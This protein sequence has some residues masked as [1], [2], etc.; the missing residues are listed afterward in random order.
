MKNQ[1]VLVAV[2]IAFTALAC[3]P[4]RARP[5]DSLK[6]VTA[7]AAVTLDD[8]LD[9]QWKRFEQ[10]RAFALDKVVVQKALVTRAEWEALLAPAG[11]LALTP[12]DLRALEDRQQ[13]AVDAARTK[14]RADSRLD[15]DRVRSQ[16]K[17]K[18]FCRDL[19]KGGLLHVHP[20]GTVDRET[21]RLILGK[22][23][24]LID[25]AKL[26]LILSAPGVTGIIYPDEHQ[27]L[28]AV[29][30]RAGATAKYS[31][32]APDDQKVIEDLFFLPPG[33]HDFDRFTGTFSAI[34]ALIFGSPY[35]PEPAMFEAFL[36][37]A[38]AHH[39]LYAEVSRAIVPKPAWFQGLDAWAKDMEAR[40]GVVI[41]LLIAFNRTKDAAFTRTKTDQLLKFPKSGALV[42]INLVAD[43]SSTPALENGQTLYLPLLAAFTDGSAAL[44]RTVHAGELGDPRN[45][46]DS[47]ILGAERIGH[48]VNL[49]ADPVTLEYA[50]LHKVPVEINL[51]SNLRLKA[52]LD[53]RKHP[54]LR[55]LRLGLPVSL[56]T[57]DEGI[58]ESTIDTD[59]EL[60]LESSDVTYAEMRQMAFN[61]VDTGFE[62]GTTRQRLDAELTAEFGA[63]EA[64]WTQ[65]TEATP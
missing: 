12:E 22:V 24:P 49:A 45:V 23:D 35:D 61:A 19:P 54:F 43:E 34:S 17:V 37:R 16:G 62:D 52:S 56:S 59:C 51:N 10:A 53:L 36:K 29:K 38:K 58:F 4:V 2:F 30:G 13:A 48:G 55:Y 7:G 64:S 63:F 47:L 46:R 6:A 57:D 50:R 26:D 40:T 3:A 11:D 9:A 42:G 39:V 27:A 65:G 15:L 18:D 32:L 31:A 28:D 8:K 1:S 33:N 25:F 14:A 5:D 41:R 44:H 21:A 60:A 20:W